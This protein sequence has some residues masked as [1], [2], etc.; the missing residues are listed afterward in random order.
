MYRYLISACGAGYQRGRSREHGSLHGQDPAGDAQ[1]AH[2]RWGAQPSASAGGQGAG[3][4]GSVAT[5][6]G[7]AAG[8]EGKHCLSLSADSG[9]TVMC[10]CRRPGSHGADRADPGD[11]PR[12][13][14]EPAVPVRNAA[15]AVPG[16]PA[17]P[18]AKCSGRWAKLGWSC[19]CSTWSRPARLYIC[20]STQPADPTP[21]GILPFS[22]QP[23]RRCCSWSAAVCLTLQLRRGPPQV[24]LQ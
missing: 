18:G 12:P 16:G 20:G 6:Q 1:R 22:L 4:Q 21:A 11:S 15:C 23:A 19:A 3:E 8:S 9:S 13:A 17:G 14:G 5:L 10:P 24:S 2:S 7:S